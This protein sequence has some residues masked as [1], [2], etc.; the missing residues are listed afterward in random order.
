NQGST[1]KQLDQDGETISDQGLHVMDGSAYL[2]YRISML[3]NSGN[4]A[5]GMS[6]H[7]DPFTRK[8]WYDI[9]APSTF[10]VRNVGKTLVN[11]TQGMKNANDALKGR[12]LEISL[13]D[14]NKNE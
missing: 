9:K 3:N 11:R 4:F 10:D 2:V 6:F 5:K 7:V 13:A 1:G 14:L 12:V 8:D